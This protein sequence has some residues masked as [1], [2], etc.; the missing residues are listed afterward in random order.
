MKKARSKEELENCEESGLDENTSFKRARKRLETLCQT[1]IDTLNER[2]TEPSIVNHMRH[3]FSSTCI[4]NEDKSEQV[5]DSLKL[6]VDWLND[7]RSCDYNVN[8][9]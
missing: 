5:F 8:T 1:L 7:N 3:C 2:I 4:I 9:F 6:L